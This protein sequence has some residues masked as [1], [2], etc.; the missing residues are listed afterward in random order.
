MEGFEVS[1]KTCFNNNLVTN[2]IE[3]AIAS[4]TSGTITKLQNCGFAGT[5]AP[6][7]RYAIAVSTACAGAGLHRHD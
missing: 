3:T 7:P 2:A 6:T 4:K 5:V 1:I